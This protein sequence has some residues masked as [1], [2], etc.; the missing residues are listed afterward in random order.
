MALHSDRLPSTAL[1]SLAAF[2]REDFLAKPDAR[3]RDFDE[4]VVFDVFQRDIERE[5]ARE[6]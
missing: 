6:A 4:L 5:L 3:G 2:V 1:R